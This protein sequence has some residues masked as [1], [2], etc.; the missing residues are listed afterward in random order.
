M[1]SLSD[2][3]RD[4]DPYGPPSRMGASPQAAV[5]Q[6]PGQSAGAPRASYPPYR[7]QEQV[8]A[9]SS[10]DE[11]AVVASANALVGMAPESQ[12]VVNGRTFVL[13][14]IGTVSAIFWG[15]NIDVKKDFR[16]YAGDGVSRL[17]QSL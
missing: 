14:C 7:T 11:Q 2:G 3:I 15:L 4:D 5:P 6:R 1:R 9:A 8:A 12:V 10:P 16:S 13:D 17:Y